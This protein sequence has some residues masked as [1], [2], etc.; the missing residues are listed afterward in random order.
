MRLISKQG[1]DPA[2]IAREDAQIAPRDSTN[3]EASA[4]QTGTIKGNPAANYI[5]TW[6]T[7]RGTDL[8]AQYFFV[9]KGNNVYVYEFLA[10]ESVWDDTVPIFNNV[11][12][13]I[14]IR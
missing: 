12:R 2:A 10:L 11:F 14:E 5:A 4:V 1:G 3:Y 7:S 9:S 8:Q 13:S 6:T